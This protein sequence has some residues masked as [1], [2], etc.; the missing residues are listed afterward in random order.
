MRFFFV[1][2]SSFSQGSVGACKTRPASVGCAYLCYLSEAHDAPALEPV[3]LPFA[4]AAPVLVEAP[5]AAALSRQHE[6][7]GAESA[8]LPFAQVV[9]ALAELP[10]AVVEFVL[11]RAG[12]QSAALYYRAACSVAFHA[13]EVYSVAAECAVP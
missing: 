1:L 4:Q 13:Q 10:V 11:S 2:L 5:V 9:P 3:L 6:I 8:S 7:E 12:S